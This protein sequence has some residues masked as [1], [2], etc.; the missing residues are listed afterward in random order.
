MSLIRK[1]A[2]FVARELAR[3][4]TADAGRELGLALGQRLGRLIDPAGVA[5]RTGAGAGTSGNGSSTES[6]EQK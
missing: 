2:V 4:I 1:G 3:A 5:H 6:K